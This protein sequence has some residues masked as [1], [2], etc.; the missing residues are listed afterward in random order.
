[1]I[2]IGYFHTCDHRKSRRSSHPASNTLLCHYPIKSS[3]NV[4]D[5]KRRS[6]E[7]EPKY[8]FKIIVLGSKGAGKSSLLKRFEF[9]EFEE[10]PSHTI[11]AGFSTHNIQLGL[12]SV[13]VRS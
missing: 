2:L 9:D 3:E 11:G 12:N 4:M 13:Q 1:M 8:S 5:D 7:D 10:V 6:W